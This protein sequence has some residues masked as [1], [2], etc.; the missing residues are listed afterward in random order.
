MEVVRVLFKPMAS[1]EK[2]TV[3][4]ETRA[5]SRLR[6]KGKLGEKR[7]LFPSG[8]KKLCPIGKPQ[9]GEGDIIGKS[10]W[11]CESSCP[12]GHKRAGPE[13]SSFGIAEKPEKDKARW[14][15]RRIA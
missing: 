5:I 1:G 13:K 7:T 6:Q 12:G 2:T 8:K 9:R 4:Q 3:F 11:T 14:E 10:K 15:A